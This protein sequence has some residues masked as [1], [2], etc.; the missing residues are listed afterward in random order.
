VSAAAVEIGWVTAHTATYPLGLL[1]DRG[2]DLDPE[3]LTL[4]G[5]PLSQRGLFGADVAAATTP[6]VLIHGIVDNRTIFTRLRR[7]LRRR[8]F[9][10]IRAFS[11]GPHTTDVRETAARLGAFVEEL[12]EETG[13]DQVYVV[14]HSLGGLI[15]RYYAQCLDRSDRVHTLVTLGTPHHGTHAA[16]LLPHRLV[17]QLCPDSDLIAEL[18]QPSD[19]ATNFLCFHS[20]LD[21]LIVPAHNARLQH[22]DLRAANVAVRGVGHLSMPINGGIVHQICAAFARRPAEA[23]RG[24]APRGKQALA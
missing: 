8:G 1:R 14:G 16:R 5:L 6:I 3:L 13:S 24:H 18:D 9:G 12:C 17:R 23:E 22:P 19:C 2:D 4:E 21:H 20:D 7:G 15:A 10:C 11:Y